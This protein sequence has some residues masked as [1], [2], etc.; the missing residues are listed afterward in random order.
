MSWV[1][2]VKTYKVIVITRI[3]NGR[4]YEIVLSDVAKKEETIHNL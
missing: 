3:G 1:I 4:G 2:R